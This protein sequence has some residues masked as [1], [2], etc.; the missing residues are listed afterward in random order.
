MRS[1]PSA[2]FLPLLLPLLFLALA[3]DL[4]ARAAPQDPQGTAADATIPLAD[5]E[6]RLVP[7]TR[8]ELVSEADDWLVRVQETC[9][10]IAANEIAARSEKDAA[11]KRALLDEMGT[12][13]TQRTSR[14]DRLNAVIAHLA[15]KGAAE[16]KIDEY[17]KFVAAVSGLKLDVT[18][19][20][21]AWAAVV[22]WLKS[23]EGGIRMGKNVLLFLLTLVLFRILSSI[24]GRLTNRALLGFKRTSDLL[25]DF[26]VSS[27]RK[28]VFFIGIVLA[29]SML[30]IDIGPFLAAI[31]AAGFVIGFA[32]QGTLSNFA[33]GIMILLYRPYD[34]GDYVAVAGV[35]GTVEAMTL[36]S[37][38]VKT[39]DNQLVVIPNS[40]IWGGII[41][42]VTGKQQR[43]VDLSFGIGYS[44]DIAKAERI[45]TDIVKKHPLVLP[46]PEPVIKLH[47]LADSSVN[48]VVRP[49]VS[50]SDYWTV[51][52][53]IT[54]AV[55]E[56]F[57]AEGV[58]I[59]F[60]QRDVHIYQEASAT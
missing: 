46:D 30:E 34:I 24:A 56:R 6:S 18:Y 14:I 12:L 51:Y 22:N 32:L 26:L 57:D 21:A 38:S 59:P 5:L 1:L 52:W 11:R 8:E 43:R 13:V 3:P 39:P 20:S 2:L 9:R 47:E 19:T 28:V 4:P 48:F 53:D 35:A 17:R 15:R 37:T 55:K 60:P 58:S 33:S 50:T 54:R 29:L 23:P 44:D 27:I 40:S 45:L 36:V 7:L 41:T 25:R 42:N 31:G 10:A 49:W 16:Q